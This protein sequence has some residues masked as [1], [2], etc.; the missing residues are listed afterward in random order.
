MK[1]QTTLCETEVCMKARTFLPIMLVWFALAGTVQAG[2]CS[3]FQSFLEETKGNIITAFKLGDM[4]TLEVEVDNLLF[5]DACAQIECNEGDIKSTPV[6][7][8]TTKSHIKLS[9]YLAGFL[10]WK[11]DIEKY[12]NL[13]F[14]P[15]G[16]V[17]GR[18]FD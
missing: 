17:R 10:F 15:A 5:W 7:W 8:L 11:D 14:T 16:L 9:P 18:S 1:A 4:E 3:E 12:R 6:Y 13:I 2:N